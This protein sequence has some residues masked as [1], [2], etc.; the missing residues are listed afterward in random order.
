MNKKLKD[1]I[2]RFCGSRVGAL[3]CNL[4]LV[5]VLFTVTRIVFVVCNSSI[6]A[7]HLSAGYV[8]Q[9]LLAGLRFDTTAI[10]YLNC[11][12]ILAFLLPLHY[13]E[14]AKFYAVMRWLFVVLNFIGLSANLCDCAYFPFTGR[15]TTF[16]VLQ[17]FSNEGNFLTIITN[18]ALPYWYLFILAALLVWVLWKGFR[19]PDNHP[20][21]NAQH[22]LRYYVAQLVLLAVASG[23]TVAGIRASPPITLL[24]LSACSVSRSIWTYRCRNERRIYHSSSPYYHIK[25]QSVCGSC[26]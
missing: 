25:C 6:Y 20:T 13:K 12:M 7:E 8:L 24:H 14:N 17:E 21:F 16:N 23:L 11:W 3:V 18:E 9:L 2:G 26:H 19:A 22:L 1:I 4:L 5:Y 10:L 15:R